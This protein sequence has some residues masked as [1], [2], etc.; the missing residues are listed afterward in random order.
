MRERPLLM[1]PGPV[2]L[3]EDVRAA[4]EAGLRSHL[5]PAFV[6]AFGSALRHMRTVWDAPAGQPFLVAGSGTLAMELAVAN[7]IEP[8]DR[9][10]VVSTGVFGERMAAVAARHGAEVDIVRSPVGYPGD[11]EGARRA[12]RD[13]AKAVSV[14]HVDTST[15]VR[16]DPEPFAT[17]AGEHGALMIVDGVCSVGGET[18]RQEAWG[19][20][21]ALTASQKAL[22]APPGLALLVASARAMEAWERR[23][24]PVQAYYADWGNWLPI[25]EGY[26]S[27]TPGYFGTPAVTL[28][29]ATSR[30]LALVVEE[31]MER[32]AARHQRLGAAC[33]RALTAL[34]FSLVPVG[35]EAAASTLSCAYL[36]DG[37]PGK[38]LLAQVA[39][40]GTILA[41]GLHPEIRDRS[42]R[43]GHMGAV[44]TPTLVEAIADLEDGLSAIGHRFMR[45][46]GVSAVKEAV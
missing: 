4:E 43:I 2:D 3:P 46:A 32:R 28:V 36:P 8:G 30:A 20:D 29:E 24:R 35:E 21:I 7:V 25:M 31:G 44:D 1:I 41:G 23:R 26:E 16:T 39:Q 45:G 42:L 6:A 22:A 14:T 27:G 40:R 34:G 12:L 19:I 37:V 33:R 15:G 17:L 5:A 38:E 11:L 13:G 9:M 10:V 18:L